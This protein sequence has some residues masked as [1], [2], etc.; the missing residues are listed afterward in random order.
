MLELRLVIDDVDYNGALETLYPFLKDIVLKEKPELAEKFD[1][2]T[3][4]P[5]TISFGTATN[6]GSPA[7]FGG[8]EY[9]P[10]RI[11]QRSTETL[12]VKHNEA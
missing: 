9:T 3:Y 4:Y 12:A 5:N 7:L 6:L 8:Y 1:G 2:F 10:E 11:N